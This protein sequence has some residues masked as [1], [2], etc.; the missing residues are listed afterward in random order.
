[1]ALYDSIK[2]L[3]DILL[4]VKSNRVMTEAMVKKLHI[5]GRFV[6]QNAYC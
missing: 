5:D 3:P 4:N 1:V 2:H 6:C